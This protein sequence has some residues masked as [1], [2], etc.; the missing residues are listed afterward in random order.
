MRTPKKSAA[1]LSGVNG[2]MRSC[3]KRFHYNLTASQR[4]RAALVPFDPVAGLLDALLNAGIEPADPGAIAADGTLR[5]FDVQGDRRGSRNGWAVLHRDHGAGGSWKSGV[6]CTWSSKSA[7]RM[8]RQE[9]DLF[10]QQ[11]RET[12][13]EAQ[14]QREAEQR[15][16]AE[17]ASM[18]WT[19]ARPAAPDHPYLLRKRI[20]PGHA[21]QQGDLLVLKIEDVNGNIRSLQ[22]IA[23]DGTKKL[24]TG[25]QKRGHFVI[26]AG[27]LPAACIVVAEGFATSMTAASQFPGAAV[28]AA[29]DAGNLLP[30][31]VAIRAKCPAAGIV[32]CA[33]D[34][35][36]T[37]GNPG[38]TAGRAA[39]AA[40]HGKLVRPIWPD[41]APEALTDLN[42]LAAWLME[43]ATC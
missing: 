17:R 28:L 6:S 30:V 9:K 22:Y 5:R 4:Q 12:K 18:L 15:A 31:A 35:R 43:S 14:R 40:V 41:G 3:K 29:V 34:D 32:I 42:D 25:G 27:A 21:R 37:P 24:L 16:A 1:T 13:A 11:M 2:G 19:Q 10:Y 20:P 39:A 7:T 36:L 26:V 38:L 33:D 23:A 8:T